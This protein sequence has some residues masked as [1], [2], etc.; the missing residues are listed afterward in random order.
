MKI[1]VTGAQGFI[2]KN[3]CVH[4]QEKN[5]TDV[6]KITRQTT[7]EDFNIAI[8]EADFIFHLA[9]VNRPQHDEE[10]DKG[11]GGLTKRIIALLSDNNRNTP[12]LLTSSI[13]AELQ[14]P[15]G[16]SKAEAEAAV[17]EYG[18]RFSAKTYVYR[19]PNV[20][21]KWCKPNYNSFIATFC[22]NIANDKDIAINDP[23]H[24]VSLVYIDDVCQ[25]FIRVLENNSADGYRDVAPCYTATV[26]EVAELIY[27][28]KESRKTLVT[29]NVGTGFCRA[30]YS[31]WLSYLRPSQFSYT[32]PSYSDARG[33]FCEMLK[34]STSGQFSFF[35]ALP[36]I[37]RGGHY[38]HSKNEKFL[39]VS[40]QA[41]Y[42]FEN[43]QTG[44][45][46]ELNV[47][48]NDFNI[49]ET[50]PGWSHDITNIG[51]ENL[52]VM[53]WANEI[54]DK[55]APDTVARALS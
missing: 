33:I 53:L 41:L 32:V 9:G 34:T 23:A 11:N 46:F 17:I 26:G 52:I 50:V 40:G 19:L 14:T 49:V 44:E 4:L 30:L 18:R 6:I 20:F 22:E 36:G 12:I 29:E 3:L 15:Y 7:D 48:A 5:Y 38:H 51:T 35:T 10:F 55:N 2:G 39:V 1:V 31:T 45:K 13:Q 42:K 43:I 27:S 21:G 8:R 28:F 37:T 24:K 47:N 25:E 16:Q 54:F